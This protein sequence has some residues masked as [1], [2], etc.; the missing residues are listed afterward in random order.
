MTQCCGSH[1]YSVN[2]MRLCVTMCPPRTDGTVTVSW[3]GCDNY[4]I[5][6]GCKNNHY[7]WIIESSTFSRQNESVSFK[8]VSFKIIITR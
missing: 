3:Q 5:V 6:G 1:G 4:A 8:I 2:F 7:V